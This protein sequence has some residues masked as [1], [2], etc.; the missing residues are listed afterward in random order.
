MEGTTASTPARPGAA[1]WIALAGL[2]I[3]E[4]MNLLDSTIATVVAPAVRDSLHGTDADTQWVVAAYTL[5]FAIL[6]VLGGRLGDMAGRRRMFVI[7]VIGFCITSAINAAAP[8]MPVLLASTALQGAFAAL[9]I[10][11]TIGLIKATFTGPALPRAL[12]F[13]G[14]VM[15][16]T[17]VTGPILGGLIT[18]ANILG[19]SW[20]AVYLVNI[21]LGILVLATVPLLTEDRSPRRPDLD[22]IGLALVAV[23]GAGLV[24][25]AINGQQA[26]WPLWTWLCVA[27]GCLALVLLALHVRS[28]GRQGRDPIVEPSLFHDRGFPA[29][30]VVS[31]VYFAISTGIVFSV[32]LVFESSFHASVLRASLI[33]L[34]FSVG[35]GIA[36][37][38]AGQRLV[39]RYGARLMPVGVSILA[40]GLATTLV[41]AL[42]MS[43]EAMSQGAYPWLL[44]IGL[45]VAGLGGG[46]TTV[47]YFTAALSGLEPHEVGSAAGLLNAVQQFG[48][49][50]GIAVF[51]TVVAAA[52]QGLSITTA[53]M[54]VLIV[55]LLLAVRV[56]IPRPT[57]PQADT[58]AKPPRT[59][60]AR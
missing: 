7:G 27:A 21:P 2:L 41:A 30:L 54:L 55:P 9:A 49:T 29:A 34:P 31:L 11:Q 8:T 1:A 19:L 35:L 46:T 32:V 40:I 28:A 56:T 20:R 45:G 39:P 18:H 16:I 58:P 10:P 25:P 47:P 48:G 6:L 57:E 51:G 50:L 53:V 26:G 33:V 24:V 14:P 52:M 4:A 43:H 60:D 12:S 36:S 15:A 42:T 44:A 22:L 13:M 23:I 3:A 17:A 59:N 5:P 37:L 38:F